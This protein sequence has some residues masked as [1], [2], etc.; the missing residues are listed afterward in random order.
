MATI[1]EAGHEIITVY[2]PRLRRWISIVRDAKTKRF[3]RWVK[4]FTIRATASI[5]TGGGHEPFT[6]EITMLM[7]VMGDVSPDMLNNL[8]EKAEGYFGALTYV[9]FDIFKDAWWLSREEKRAIKV[10][11]G[12]DVFTTEELTKIYSLAEQTREPE[13]YLFTKVKWSEKVMKVGW[14]YLEE[15]DRELLKE[16]KE[17]EAQVAF[18]FELVLRE[19]TIKKYMRWKL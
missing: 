16:L 18:I 12:R 5:E 3:I 2:N 14:E 13:Q 4:E 19:T 8:T 15:V 1:T 11:Q 6:A 17:H 10:F 9:M 7:P